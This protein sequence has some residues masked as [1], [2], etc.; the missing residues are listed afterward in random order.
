[1]ADGETRNNKVTSILN[2]GSQGSTEINHIGQN[3]QNSIGTNNTITTVNQTYTNTKGN[4]AKVISGTQDMN[5]M[6][7]QD[8]Q[9]Q[10]LGSGELGNT[11]ASKEME[12]VAHNNNL[13]SSDIRKIKLNYIQMNKRATTASNGMSRKI[14]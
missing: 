1:M 9:K 13:P 12:I 5:N 4:G 2:T 11:I 10:N 6:N 14:P 7:I 3:L 8:D